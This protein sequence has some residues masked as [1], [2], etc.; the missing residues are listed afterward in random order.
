[1]NHLTL[2]GTYKAMGAAHGQL[3][4]HAGVN[5]PP[6]EAFDPAGL[7]PACLEIT[8]REAPELLC[9]ARALAKTA[10]IPEE[11]LLALLLTAPLGQ[12]Q[13]KNL[14]TCSVV[15]ITPNRSTSGHTL[16][17]RNY[18]FT[19]AESRHTATTYT[20]CP[21]GA[22]ASLGNSDVMIGREDG[23]NDA[24]LFVGMSASFLPGARPGLAFWLIV[25]LLLDRCATVKEA[26]EL[27]QTLTHAQSRNY[28]LADSS[29]EAVVVEAAL[30]GCY[31]RYPEN[32]VVAMTNHVLSD[33]L[34]GREM[35]IPETSP[36]RLARLSALAHQPGKISLEDL[37]DT[38]RDRESGLRAH[39]E[40]FGQH[41]GTIWSVA[42]ELDG[43]PCLEISEVFPEGAMTYNMI[44]FEAC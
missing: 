2:K 20:T 11:S 38:L 32:G 7:L 31:L 23:M 12:T 28:L 13:P 24:G 9:E 15:A 42:T 29:G 4:K 40:I 27:I 14:P 1:M 22:H 8:A 34:H 44:Q 5:L 43:Q 39:G 35:F 10:G 37:K 6:A 16:V 17:G 25:R 36:S 41:F 3:M 19:Y 21:H 33:P 18:D 26:L 30:E